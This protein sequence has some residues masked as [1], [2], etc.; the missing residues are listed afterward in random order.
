MSIR[1]LRDQDKPREK[2]EKF[3]IENLTDSELLAVILRSGG[4]DNSVLELSQELINKFGDLKT[5]VQQ[6]IQTLINFKNIG[7]A[8]ASCIRALGEIALRIQQRFD[9]EKIVIKD[10]FK[11]FE[12]IKRDFFG[13]NK[14]YLYVICLDARHKVISKSIVSIGILNETLAHPREIFHLAI[15]KNA[16]SIILI[17]NH[18]SQDPTPS[19]EDVQV[20]ER[21]IKA[22][23][24]LGIT[25]IDHLVVCD[26]D[27]RSI[28]NLMSASKG[29]ENI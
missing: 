20:T 7:K 19:K 28:K 26:H 24:I 5:L 10:P 3:G 13:K 25:V 29:G 18:P 23:I 22:G 15:S 4:S 27:F 16:E 1:N 14:E 8:K 6:D 17:H 2:I 21:I 9:E 11:A 12:Y